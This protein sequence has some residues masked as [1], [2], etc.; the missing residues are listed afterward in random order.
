MADE[1]WMS[2][3]RGRLASV[4]KARTPLRVAHTDH[5]PD[6][7]VGTFSTIKW[8]LFRLSRFGRISPSGY[9]FDRQMGTLSIDKN[10]FTL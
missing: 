2:P 6:E 5:N 7:G 1:L 4:L 9:F 3:P 8:V 10:R